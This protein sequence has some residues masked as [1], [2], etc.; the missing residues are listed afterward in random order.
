M[1]LMLQQDT[2]D[3]FVIATGRT[4]TVQRLVEIAFDCVGL[5]WR[6]HVVQD[7]KFMRP[8]EVDLLVGDPTKAKRALGWEP[9]VSFEQMV[10]IMVAADIERLKA[11]HRL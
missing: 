8:A 3:D 4:H 7:D 10:E 2:P 5:D 1:W 6:K 11:E 9:R